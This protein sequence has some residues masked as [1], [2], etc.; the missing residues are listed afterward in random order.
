M[1]ELIRQIKASMRIAHNALDDT[2]Q[3]DILAGAQDL[4][5]VGIRPYEENGKLK[6]EALI[7]K[8]LELYCKAQEDYQGKGTNYEASYAGLRDA[9]SLCGSYT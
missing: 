7:R 9:M 1:Q 6:E 5:R 3:A 4:Q 2:I 8:A